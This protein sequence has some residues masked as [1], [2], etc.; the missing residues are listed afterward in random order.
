MEIQNVV[1]AYIAVLKIG[2]KSEN[3][4]RSYSKDIQKFIN[5]FEIKGDLWNWKYFSWQISQFLWFF[6]IINVSLNGLIRT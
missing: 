2:E 5:H 3:T 4:I 6:G 1:S